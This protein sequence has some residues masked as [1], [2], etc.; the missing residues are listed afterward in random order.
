M[1]E[2]YTR[3]EMGTLFT[4]QARMD[5]W[6][7]VEQAA[8]H[9]LVDAGRAPAAAAAALDAVEHVDVARAMAREAQIHHDLAAFVDV[10]AED[11]PDAAGWIHYGLTSS[12]VVDTALGLQLRSA[13]ELVLAGIDGLRVAVL[14][15]ARQHRGTI[16]LGRTH[17]MPAEVTT[18]GAKLAGWWHQLSRDRDRVAAAVA[19]ASVGKL[20]GA[21]GTYSGIGPDIEQ[22]VLARLGIDRDPSAT[23]IVQRDRHAALLSTLAVLGGTIERIA[24]EVRH[25]QRGDVAEAA[26]PFGSGQ[27]G[28]SAMPHKR[29]PIVAEQLCGLARILRANAG[30]ALENIA[31][32]H[33]RDI[34]HSST[35]RVILPDSL[36]LADHMLA[37]ATW[38]VAGLDVRVERMQAN[39]A[40]QHGVIASQRV[41]LALVDAGL[42]RDDAYREVQA[43]SAAVLD[44][45][46]DSL[47]A[48]LRARPAVTDALADDAIATLVDPAFVPLGITALFDELERAVESRD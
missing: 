23:Q 13:G 30:V 46:A 11:A 6:L 40:A 17:G 27:K 24:L 18:F 41:L 28:S 45:S 8:L 15:R 44:G 33:E 47:A 4:D 16:M 36:C 26:E 43:A 21:V 39:V 31:L 48:A 5:R 3:P 34:S 14:D 2:R 7:R 35:E 20:S 10:V 9:A 12:D 29:N 22:A 38:I 42:T 19:E 25:L 37:K 32:W 1:I